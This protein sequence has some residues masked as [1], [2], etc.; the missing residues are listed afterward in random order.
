MPF[1]AFEKS[2][3]HPQAPRK[4]KEDTSR[5]RMRATPEVLNAIA[6]LTHA[7]LPETHIGSILSRLVAMAHCK[8]GKNLAPSRLRSFSFNGIFV[9]MKV[10]SVWHDG[11]LYLQPRSELGTVERPCRF[12]RKG[13]LHESGG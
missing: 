8:G 2:S 7:R 12:Q 9:A 5:A 1:S 11:K 13:A 3:L 4:P 6:P 10:L